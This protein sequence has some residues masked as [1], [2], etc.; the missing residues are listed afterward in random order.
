MFKNFV[1]GIV[2]LFIMG[3]TGMNFGSSSLDSAIADN[4]RGCDYEDRGDY[5][6]AV[7][8]YQKSADAGF[9]G[10]KANLG[11][12][13]Y[14]GLGVSKNPSYAVSLLVEPAQYGLANSQLI[15]GQAMYFGIGTRQDAQNGYA[16][17]QS[18]A[19]K[20]DP[21]ARSLLNKINQAQWQ[22]NLQQLQNQAYQYQLQQRYSAPRNTPHRSV[23]R[24]TPNVP[25]RRP[26][27]IED[28]PDKL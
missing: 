6:K 8:Y 22:H 21:Q 12:C 11:R 4:N 20:G 3:C 18:A 25:E 7:E 24:S 19:A 17:I 14:F 23:Q 13:Y 10:G 2:F 26:A 27:P 5:A 16:L 1:L 28:V 15:L 9:Y